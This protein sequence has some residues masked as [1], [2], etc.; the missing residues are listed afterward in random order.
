MRV[1]LVSNMFPPDYEG[2]LE[3]SA[4]FAAQGLR[5]RGHEVHVATSRFREEFSGAREDP[6]WVHRV[7]RMA[8]VFEERPGR[9]ANKIETFRYILG[10]TTA[11]RDNLP[12]L[13]RHLADHTYDVG[14]IFGTLGLGPAT[15]LAF[16]EREIPVLWHAGDQLLADHYNPKPS[17]ELALQLLAGRWRRLERQVRFHEIAFISEFHRERCR[18]VGLE[19]G[20]SSVIPRGIEF[21]I[22]EAPPTEFPEPRTLLMACRINEFKGLHI[23]VEA[24]ALLQARRPDLEWRLEVA[25]PGGGVYLERLRRMAREGAIQARVEFTGR[26]SRD[27]ILEKMRKAY[28]F[29]SASIMGEPLGRTN[30]EAL[31]CGCALV[32][33]DDGAM[34]EYVTPEISGLVYPKHEARA[35]SA[36]LERLLD[37]PDLRH[38]LAAEGLRVVHDRFSMRAVLDLTEARLHGVAG[39]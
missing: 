35:L 3:L 17:H 1:L 37:D 13:R 34:L 33:S 32:G 4:F 21:P 26:H 22:A 10:R 15:A 20:H 14:Y 36:H 25:G 9:L 18:E 7:F 24:A 39:G 19:F 29:V 5:E 2:G 16:D 31:A 23:A 30:I 28:A 6:D 38:R 11:A 8:P 12:A 27:Q